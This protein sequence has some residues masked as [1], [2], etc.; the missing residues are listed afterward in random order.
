MNR[1]AWLCALL[2]WELGQRGQAGRTAS[3][4]AIRSVALE[5]AMCADLDGGNCWPGQRRLV[6]VCGVKGETIVAL[7]RRWVETGWLVD[8]GARVFG[9]A[10]VFPLSFPVVKPVRNSVNPEWTVCGLISAGDRP[11]RSPSSGGDLRWRS[12]LPEEEI[13]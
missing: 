8:T 13:Q 6:R 1:L 4:S 3:Q 2:E 5:L 11:E 10:V 7:R 12:N 9:G